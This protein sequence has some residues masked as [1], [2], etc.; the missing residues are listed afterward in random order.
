MLNSSTLSI[1]CG[2]I[3]LVLSIINSFTVDTITPSFQR[4]EILAGLAGVGLMLIGVLWSEYKPQGAIKKDLVGHQGFYIY[5]NL[6]DFIKTEL[7]WGSKQILTATAAATVLIFWE[8][9]VILK[10]GLI[11]DQTFIPGAISL[12]ARETGRIISLVKTTLFPGRKEFDSIIKDLP[13]ILVCPLEKKGW[14]IIGGWS[15]RCFTKSDE[16]WINGWAEKISNEL[17]L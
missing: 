11:N 4:S 7:A 1:V 9:K 15:E 8:N 13:S 5:E 14:I 17:N 12:R 3:I 10:R 16:I 6:G 2:I